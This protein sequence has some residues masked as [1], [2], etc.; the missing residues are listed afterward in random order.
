VRKFSILV[1]SKNLG[2]QIKEVDPPKIEAMPAATDAAKPM[3][4]QMA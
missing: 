2:S 3:Q 4:M 1:Q